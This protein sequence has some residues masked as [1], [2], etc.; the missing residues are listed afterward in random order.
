[1]IRPGTVLV[2]ID[3]VQISQ[4]AA[5]QRRFGARFLERVYTPA[6]LSYCLSSPGTSAAR[7][8]ARF[9]AKEATRKVLRETDQGLGWRSVEVVRTPGGWCELALHGE[10][11]VLATDAGI[12]S[13]SVSLSHEGDYAS[14]VV[15]AERRQ[16]PPS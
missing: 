3:L 10:A 7:L 12:I 8:A 6:E 14:A 13:L 16:E 9:A 15:V 1:M 11:D 5:S 4:L 2:G